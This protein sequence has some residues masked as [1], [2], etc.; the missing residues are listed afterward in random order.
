[1]TSMFETTLLG[2]VKQESDFESRDERAVEIGAVLP[3][4][5]QLGWDT[6]NLS[7]IY[8]QRPLPDGKVDYDL[9]I[10]GESRIMIEVKRWKRILDDE[11]ENQLETYC[12]SVRPRPKLAVLTSGRSWRLYLAPTADKGKNSVLKKFEEVDITVDEFAEVES[13]FSQFLARNSMVNFKSVLSPARDL[14]RK[15]QDYQEQKRLLTNAWNELVNDR[16]SLAG[17]FLELAENKGITTNQENVMRLLESLDESLVSEVSTTGKSQNRPASFDLLTS[18]TGKKMTLP[19]E[20]KP[21]SWKNFLLEIC[22]LMQTRH[23]ENFRKNITSMP[24][25]F[26][27]IKD[28]KFSIPVGDTGIYAKLGGSS[29]I[30]AACYEIVT[31]FDYPKDSLVIKDSKGAIL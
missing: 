27:K 31:K 30:R 3:V 14:Y 16:N 12:R 21:K 4:L 24:D 20:R 22:E 17:L 29:E 15:L 18:P 28:S 23:P 5:E 11:D 25:R 2:I 6:K 26:S 8:P 10:D 9:Q 13:T 7:E 19:V 1:M